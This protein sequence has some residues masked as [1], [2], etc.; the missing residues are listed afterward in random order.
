LWLIII[1]CVIKVFVQIELGRFTITHGE[2]TLAALDQ[3]PGPRLGVSWIVW[4]WL[5]MMLASLGQL[6]GIVGGVG[7]SFALSFP[8]TGD[9]RRAI[10][11]PSE[12]ELRQYIKWD[13]D[14]ANGSIQS[15]SLPP[16]DQKRMQRGHE[17][18]A[19]RLQQLDAEGKSASQ[20]LA[21][22]RDLVAAE[23]RQNSAAGSPG[24][25]AQ[26]QVQ[27]YQQQ[28]NQLLSPV[29]WDDM[30]WAIGTTLFTIALLYRGSYG[31]IQNLST[32]LVVLFTFVTV[33]N[34]ISLQNTLQWHISGAE[35]LRG[36]SFNLPG[37]KAA[38]A[39]ALATFG[40]I[41]VGASELVAYPYWCLEKGYAKFAGPRS[42]DENWARRA[43][44]WMKVMRYDAWASMAIYTVATLAFY[45][46]G[47][48]VLHS[49]GRDPEGMRMVSTLATAY[50]PV[51]G[52]YAGWLFLIG[53]IAVLYSTFLVANAGHARTLTD[54]LK[55]F[56]LVE[57]NNQRTHD[58][59]ISMFSVLLPLV[60][61]ALFWTR[62]NPVTLVLLGGTTQAIMLPML[63]FAAIYFRYFKTDPRLRPSPLWD[64]M[65]LV[66]CVGLLIA[67][68]WNA[69]SELS[70][71]WSMFQGH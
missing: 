3:V 68:T 26:A 43:R 13:A 17:I 22:V 23:S 1:G 31:I 53:A 63:G 30:Y 34:V 48:A 8:I 10:E 41:G 66:S 45:F 33:G 7:Q 62:M 40:I 44:G 57:H 15:Q 36:L 24:G 39:T 27:D 60:C 49:E 67:G 20:A 14:L 21:L 29:T 37:G 9:Y 28:V 5:V 61:L 59:L 42:P 64:V 32:A 38:L 55:V 35:I 50:V 54:C 19:A 70:K 2:T 52:E 18:L 71:H 56:G 16:A 51:F 47:V 6:G 12:T 46:T 69:W 65:L 4:Y 58:R 25:D 11:L